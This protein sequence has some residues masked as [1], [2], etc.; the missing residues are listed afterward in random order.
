MNDAQKINNKFNH[1]KVNKKRICAEWLEFNDFF[2]R[3]S[4]LRYVWFESWGMSSFLHE[5]MSMMLFFTAHRF[6][7]ESKPFDR[8]TFRRIFLDT[9]QAKEEITDKME[10]EKKGSLGWDGVIRVL[11][12]VNKAQ[13][14]SVGSSTRQSFC[15]DFGNGVFSK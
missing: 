11:N 12:C 3:S 4:C 1:F 2:L 6:S 5:K 10:R 14:L 13:S 8:W 9:Y 15:S 7:R